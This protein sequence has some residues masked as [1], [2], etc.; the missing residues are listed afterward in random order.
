MLI[1]ECKGLGTTKLCNKSQDVLTP[2]FIKVSFFEGEISQTHYCKRY[3]SNLKRQHNLFCGKP[4][5]ICR[6]TCASERK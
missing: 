3:L 4:H 5:L 2:F 1:L 6:V